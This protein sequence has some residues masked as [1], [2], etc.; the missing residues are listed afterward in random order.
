MDA[1]VGWQV[2]I[3]TRES[4]VLVVI[5]RKI[6]QKT[7]L[8]SLESVALSISFQKSSDNEEFFPTN[9]ILTMTLNAFFVK[10]IT[11]RTVT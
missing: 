11:L 9:K 1:N 4:V 6:F 2:V 8:S 5:T 3:Q 10:K 7:N